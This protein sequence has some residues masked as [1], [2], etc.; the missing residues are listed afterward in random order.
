M[1][2]TTKTYCT[3][4]NYE[5]DHSTFGGTINFSDFCTDYHRSEKSKS[6]AERIESDWKFDKQC[7]KN[8]ENRKQNV[9]CNKIKETNDK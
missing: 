3:T 6:W 4:R 5:S 8:A 9:K 2:E 7:R 1:T